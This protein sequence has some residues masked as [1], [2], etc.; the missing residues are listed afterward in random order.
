MSVLRVGE[1]VCV[2][3]MVDMMLCV[4]TMVCVVMLVRVRYI[5]MC[6]CAC[7]CMYVCVYVCVCVCWC[8]CVRRRGGKHGYYAEP[9]TPAVV[10]VP[11]EKLRCS[12]P[13]GGYVV[14]IGLTRWSCKGGG[15]IQ[16]LIG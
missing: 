11:N 8:V 16:A 4:C 3:C 5:C 15:G 9:H 2:I 12:V 7:V 1:C 13:P 14:S 10:S 6:V